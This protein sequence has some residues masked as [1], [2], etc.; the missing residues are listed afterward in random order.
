MYKAVKLSHLK[1]VV[2]G[3]LLRGALILFTPL[4][5]L[6][7]GSVNVMWDAST[8]TTVT[9]YNVYYGNAS[10]NY[11]STVNAG[12]N[13]SAA[14]SNLA[15]GKTYYIAVTAYDALGNESDFSSEVS[16]TVPGGANQPPTISGIA[17]Q[18]V[19]TGQSTGAAGFT[20]GDPDTGPA[21]LTLS[22]V[23]SNTTLV[24]AGN[25]VFGGS[26]ANR[27]VTVTPAAGQTGTAQ[28]TVYVSDGALTV[29]TTFTVAVQTQTTDNA[30][31]IS[32]IA[33]QNISGG[34]GTGALPFTIGDQDT[35]T[36]GLIL[37]ATSSNPT[38]VPN[39]NIV[40]G[41]SGANRTVTVTPVAGQ[42][43]TAQITVYVSDGTLTTQ[44]SFNVNVQGQ[45][46]NHAPTI[47]SIANQN[48]ATS[49]PTGAIP[50]TVN[51]ADTGA[52]SLSVSATSSNPTL[53]PNANIVLGG[54]GA[55]RTVTITPAAG[56]TGTAQ[57][58]LTVSDGSL[59]AQ[60]SFSVIVQTEVAIPTSTLPKTSTYNGLFYEQDAVQ[61]QS[62]GSIKLTVTS[63]GKYSGQLQMAAGKYSFSGTFGS[64]CEGTNVITRKG[65]TPLY[66][67]FSL[68]PGG[69]AGQLVGT[70][71]DGTWTA[72]ISGGEAVYN[73]KT[74]PAPFAGTYTLAIPGQNNPPAFT[75][76]NSFGS[77][78]VNGNGSVKL[79]GSLADGTKISQSSGLTEDGTWPL[80]VPL[81][82]GQG[83]LIGWVSFANRAQDDLNGPVNW[84]KA[85][86]S[87]SKYYPGGLAIQGEAMGSKF[88]PTGD[89]LTFGEA[90]L[91][92]GSAGNELIMSLKLSTKNGVFT[93]LMFN[94]T[95]GKGMPFQGAL[96][97]KVNTG[98]GFL[99]QTNQSASVIVTQ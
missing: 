35:G 54:S 86:N 82:S 33:A 74:R 11:A 34:H 47:G 63:K 46:Q 7:A 80:F 40:L 55:N 50:F 52:S 6:Q 71:S 67:S 29:Q 51:D 43:G 45:Q 20:V 58:T 26:G 48:I 59:T 31:T 28:I 83:M 37:A 44:T 85:A 61:L 21:G 27:T 3:I 42:T 39:A 92:L 38:L 25:V 9:G 88:L 96:L 1:G 72:Q 4:A 22:A 19:S 15:N 17:N 77:L 2:V 97:Q 70:L 41:G 24:P 5:S 57:I 99:L 65:S 69:A 56:Q 91:Q 79:A 49:Q 64:F 89:K 75:L 73:A 87:V 14:L 81:Y 90:K 95:T 36:S 78:T 30:P 94:P 76:G 93:G 84:I 10:R 62:A 13:V 68:Q 12:L 8:N 66:I 98:Y 53:V 23:S 18:N 32:A 16:Y 60:T